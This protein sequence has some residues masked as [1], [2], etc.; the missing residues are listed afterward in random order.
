MCDD[1]IYCIGIESFRVKSFSNGL[2]SFAYQRQHI[3]WRMNLKAMSLHWHSKRNLKKVATLVNC[4]VYVCNG[5][6]WGLD[7]FQVSEVYAEEYI[8]LFD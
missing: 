6:Y 4:H 2:W 8:R 7:F 5:I 1:N 3:M